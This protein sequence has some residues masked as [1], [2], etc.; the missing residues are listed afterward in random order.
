MKKWEQS[1]IKTTYGVLLELFVKAGN[2][3]CAEALYEVL[4]K[5]R[6]LVSS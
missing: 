6:E 5:K 3:R 1:Y 4:R 2:I